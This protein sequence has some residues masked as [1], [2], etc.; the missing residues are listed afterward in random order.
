MGQL[1][2]FE[3]DS[4][5][6]ELVRPATVNDGVI[7]IDDRETEKFIKI[8]SE[9]LP[10]LDAVKFVPASGAASRMFKELI[11]EYSD[12]IKIESPELEQYQSSKRLIENLPK[13][14]FYND[15]L[16][17]CESDKFTEI[18]D[19]L[20]NSTGLNY[21]NLPKGL[22]KFHK[23][24]GST[25][26]AFEEHLVEGK[27]YIMGK[28]NMCK[29]HF[30]VPENY[31]SYIKNQLE[32]LLTGYQADGS[33][34]ELNYSIQDPA[35]DT[36]AVDMNNNPVISDRGELNFRPAGHGA[37]IQNLNSIDADMIFIKNIDN[38]TVEDYLNETVKFKKLLGGYL[39][40]IKDKIHNSLK[41]LDSGNTA[42]DEF[43]DIKQFLKKYLF[44]DLVD[45]TNLKILL[46]RPIRVCG[47]VKNE[48]EPG[49]GPF[50]T[51][52]GIN[53]ESLQIVESAQVDTDSRSQLDIWNSSTHFNPVDIACWVRDFMGNKFDFNEYVD[54][55]AGI[56]T[57]KSTDGMEIKALEL[58][59]LW[60]G[61][62]ADWLTVFIEVPLITFSPVKT[63]FDLLRKEHQN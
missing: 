34:F 46:N 45:N 23:Y 43:E 38:V 61:A 63:V 35:T 3:R 36:I 26:T 8:Y 57:R 14:A 15:L 56:I 22:I 59:G 50:W 30:T 16:S 51:G 55:D 20:L 25:R 19:K 17:V 31:S 60:N 24:N 58:P 28:D 39:I 1:S 4:I 29:I 52:Y 32:S 40:F 48:G 27:H 9:S 12:F 2:Q 10:S 44:I 5:P 62:M 41:L 7:R 13:F 49:G 11:S 54:S 33:S 18:I 37:L 21:S 47:V 53:G 42:D 6:V